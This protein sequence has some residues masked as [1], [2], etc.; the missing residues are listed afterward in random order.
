MRDRSV[1]DG[2]T[3][4]VIWCLLPFVLGSIPLVRGTGNDVSIAPHGGAECLLFQSLPRSW[5]RWGSRRQHDL[6]TIAVDRLHEA[7]L[8]L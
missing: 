5:S 7:A 3:N 4:K 2:A 1:G 6:I 8:R